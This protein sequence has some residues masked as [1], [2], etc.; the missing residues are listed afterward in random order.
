MR[1]VSRP[2]SHVNV[3]TRVGLFFCGSDSDRHFGWLVNP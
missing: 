1:L 2:I 3:G